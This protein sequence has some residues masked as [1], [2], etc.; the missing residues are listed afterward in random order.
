MYEDEESYNNSIGNPSCVEVLCKE[1]EICCSNDSD[2]SNCF[3]NG[4]SVISFSNQPDYD[5]SQEE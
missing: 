2:F 1:E 3:A 4:I 5:Q